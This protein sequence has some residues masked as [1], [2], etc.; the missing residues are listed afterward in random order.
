MKHPDQEE[1]LEATRLM[2]NMGEP[3]S[4]HS[5]KPEYTLSYFFCPR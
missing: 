4:P 3:Q 5:R 1:T 2:A